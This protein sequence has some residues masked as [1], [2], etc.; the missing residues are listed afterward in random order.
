MHATSRHILAVLSSVL[1]L[2]SLAEVNAADT[3]PPHATRET[4]AEKGESAAR[5]DKDIE[6]ARV[7]DVSLKLDGNVPAGSGPFPAVI[8]VHGGG[9]TGGNKRVYVTPILEPLSRAGF[10]WFSIDYRLAPKFPFPAAIEDVDRAIEYV[11]AHAAEYK[12][13]PK[14]IALLGESAGGHIVSYVG[15]QTDPRWGVAAVVSF[16]GPHNLTGEL[17][18]RKKQ[19]KAP[20]AVQAFLSIKTF[21]PPS[22]QRVEAASPINH[23]HEKMPPYLL[24]HGKADQIV[25]YEQS[26][27]MC[28]RLQEAG[29][30]CELYTIEGG[31]HG[32][33]SWEKTPEYKQ[34]VVAWLK[35][36]LHVTTDE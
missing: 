2:V 29:N 9:F 8:V 28:E 14:R 15:T 13:D 17:E 36:E 27:K 18:M 6:Y 3:A 25:D 35:Q 21:D 32:M 19:G 16:Y 26:V 30:S 23:I 24:V 4:I 7:G 20:S 22:I 31:A 10:A 34:K 5:F 11:K 12:V 33:G 1:P